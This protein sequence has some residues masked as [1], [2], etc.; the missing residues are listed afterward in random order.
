MPDARLH[1]LNGYHGETEIRKRNTAELVVCAD[2]V[3][4]DRDA[5][6][7][8][9]PEQERLNI[10]AVDGAEQAYAQKG[11]HAFQIVERVLS[12]V[13]VMGLLEKESRMDT[14]DLKTVWYRVADQAVAWR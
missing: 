10:D 11:R 1:H 8:D 7:T 6:Q 12:F 2:A 5:S 13:L 9:N 14:A 3:A 4:E